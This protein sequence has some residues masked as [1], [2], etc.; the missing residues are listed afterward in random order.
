MA[1]DTQEILD[2]RTE[3]ENA[4]PV[5]SHIVQANQ[6]MSA[7]A[8]IMEATVNGTPVT[9]LCGYTWVP[10]RDPR[11]YPPCPKCIEIFEF[12]RDLSR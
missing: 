5:H 2:T 11:K 8:R 3:L 4:D 9:A 10:H 6:E 1:I 12:A 7:G